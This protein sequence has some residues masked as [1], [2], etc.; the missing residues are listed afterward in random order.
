[1]PEAI[2]CFLESNSFEDTVRKAVSLG[3][4]SDTQAA[5][6]GSIAEAYYQGVPEDILKIAL[7]KLD[8]NLL[9]I[10]QSWQKWLKEEIA[11]STSLFLPYYAMLE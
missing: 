3:G 11:P 4:D 10:L 7:T 5:I 8:A 9:I 1:M 2:I 6:A